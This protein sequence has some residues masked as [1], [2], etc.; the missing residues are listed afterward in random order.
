MLYIT[1]KCS[2]KNKVYWSQCFKLCTRKF[3]FLSVVVD[4]LQHESTWFF[5]P[6][7]DFKL[8]AEVVSNKSGSSWRVGRSEPPDSILLEN[9][10]EFRNIRE[11][12]PRAKTRN[13]YKSN[14]SKKRCSSYGMASPV[15]GPS[16]KN[17]I[18]ITH[19]RDKHSNMLLLAGMHDWLIYI[20]IY[21]LQVCI[22]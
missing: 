13:A 18:F 3:F 4:Q 12:Q 8:E 14:T 19:Q 22:I 7:S 1:K 15:G 10:F 2:G 21:T 20:Y 5:L 9:N 16:K 17:M 6:T 11:M